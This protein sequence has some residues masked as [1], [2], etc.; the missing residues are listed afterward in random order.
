MQK[1]LLFAFQFN[2]Q[3]I[4]RRWADENSRKNEQGYCAFKIE[5][6]ETQI[7]R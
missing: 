1:G 7:S 3:T 4:V 6:P 2:F 5:P